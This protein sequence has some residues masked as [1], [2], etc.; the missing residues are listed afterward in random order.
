MTVIKNELRYDFEITTKP[1]LDMGTWQGHGLIHYVDEDLTFTFNVHRDGRTGHF[2]FEDGG[3]PAVNERVE[4]AMLRTLRQC[5]DFAVE[6]AQERFA[7][8]LY[9]GGSGAV[10]A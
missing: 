2:V 1:F 10:S 5:Y 3:I 9:D 4:A 6:K 7:A 8:D